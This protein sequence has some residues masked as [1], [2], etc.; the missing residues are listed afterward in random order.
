MKRPR[1][2][3]CKSAVS[4]WIA[5]SPLTMRCIIILIWFFSRT[6][7]P[8]SGI[9]TCCH[10]TIPDMA[11]TWFWMDENILFSSIQNHVLAMSLGSWADPGLCPSFQLFLCNHQLCIFAAVQYL[12]LNSTLDTV[13][14]FSM[15]SCSTCSLL[16][17]IYTSF[18]HKS[19]QKINNEQLTK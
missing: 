17:L 14:L 12:Y 9:V 7:V 5:I 4:I 11:R 15:L 3:D 2:P 13:W 18:F 19:W 10:V 8:I 6:E 16:P 1:C